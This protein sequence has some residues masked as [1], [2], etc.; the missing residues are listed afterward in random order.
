MERMR[1][2]LWVGDARC[3]LILLAPL[4]ACMACK[5]VDRSKQEKSPP[6]EIV[7]TEGG[8]EMVRIPAGTCTMGSDDGPDDQRP[9]HEVT[10]AE[11]LIDRY[12]TTQEHYIRLTADTGSKFKGPQ[13]PAEM[14]SWV[15]AALYCNA[16]SEAEGLTPCYSEG[17]D[18]ILCDLRADGY[19]LPTEAEWEYACRAGGDGAYFFGD[20]PNALKEHAWFKENAAK[21]THPV[22]EK[23]PNAWGLYDMH[24]NVA[25]WC[26]DLYAAGYY[27]VSPEDNPPGPEGE[28][29]PAEE[30]YV[31][32]GGS[33]ASSA[34]SCETAS[35]AADTPGFADACFP[36]ET[37]GFR[38]VRKAPPKEAEGKE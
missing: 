16:R 25:E 23:K 22:G 8:I 27:E 4:L 34:E 18:G 5:P 13:R 37:L 30:K 28:D 15:K 29:R 17:D 9:A 7:T 26:N 38:C 12:E 33:W 6:P 24:G 32:R 2:S 36:R 14:V 10:V 19:R 1:M 21:E 35:R 20:D 3:R 11:F 31:L